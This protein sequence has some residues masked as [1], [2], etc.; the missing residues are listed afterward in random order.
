MNEPGDISFRVVAPVPWFPFRSKTF[1]RYSVYS[2]V[3]R[4]E[5]RSEVM[6][7]HPKYPVLPK[8]GMSI[9]PVL[10]AMFT[11][12]VLQKIQR[13]GYDFDIIDSHYFYPDGVAA[14]ML[15][16][17]LDKPVMITARGSD[18]NLI[19][20]YYIPRKLIQWAARNARQIA[21]VSQSLKDNLAELGV[22]KSRINVFRNGVDLTKFRPLDRDVIRNEMGL[23]KFTILSVG[24]L[25]ELKG[26]H[27]IIEAMMNLPDVE[28]IIVGEGEMRNRLE[29]MASD[30]GV[31]DRV[32]F[33][34]NVSQSELCK[35]YNSADVLVLASS[36][37]GMANVLLEAMACGT[38]VIATDAGGNREV[39]QGSNAGLIISVRCSEAIVSSI[40]Q[41]KKQYPPR[42][43]IREHAETL[44]WD[45]TSTSIKSCF[46]SICTN[47]NT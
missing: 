26:H 37:E 47:P 6:V 27:L 4:R 7:Y 16:K 22:D 45:D 19:S 21:T 20:K 29:T 30:Y 32:S 1:G 23:T 14:V 8:V 18:I 10:L 31:D 13:G 3:P 11:Y 5:V 38:P 15:G 9:S 17:W 12:R 2:S 25:I 24:N 35:L 34:G 46:N 41:L 42:R 36:R 33:M 43:S 39:I 40:G 28:L 44:S